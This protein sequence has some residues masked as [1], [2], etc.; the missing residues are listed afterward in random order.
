M[1]KQ[2]SSSQTFTEDQIQELLG[3][4]RLIRGESEEAYRK[5]WSTFVKAYNPQTLPDWLEVNQLAVKNWEQGRIR[6][7]NSAVI[8]GAM[9]E[10]LRSL[11][12][13]IVAGDISNLVGNR[14]ARLAHDY[15]GRNNDKRRRARA[16][17]AGLGVSD[18][19]IV[20][21]AMNLRARFDCI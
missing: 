2:M 3:P 15:F 4:P 11:L 1:G 21:E 5:W 20:A 9:V 19:Q 17:V 7:S 10:A 16:E 6:R 8:E 13:P 14:S 18:D 12:I